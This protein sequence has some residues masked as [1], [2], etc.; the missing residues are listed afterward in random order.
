MQLTHTDLKVF[1]KY[2]LSLKTFS[3]LILT[4]RNYLNMSSNQ[5]NQIHTILSLFQ[6]LI[7]LKFNIIGL[8]KIIDF[9]SATFAHEHHGSIIN[10]R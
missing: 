4:I 7:K 9:G 10:T 2:Q 8:I 3:L 6:S 5:I 1:L